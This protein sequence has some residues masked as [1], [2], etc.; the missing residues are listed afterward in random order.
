MKNIEIANCCG[1]CTH[2]NRPKKPLD[3][4]AHYE[5]AKT[6]RWCYLH[7]LRTTREC[8]CDDYEREVK[9]GGVPACKRVF[10]FNE[11][12]ERIKAIIEEM[13]KVGIEEI[14]IFNKIFV[15]HNDWLCERIAYS[16]NDEFSFYKV[17][18]DEGRFDEYE[19][20]LKEALQKNKRRE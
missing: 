17:R 15:L 5:V 8:V 2:C 14:K 1:T 3:H 16:W 6:Q 19:K 10:K 12:A 18:D 4:E 20:L 9:K 11:R 7:K 13:K